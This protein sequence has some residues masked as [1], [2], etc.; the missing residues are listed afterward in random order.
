MTRPHGE[1]MLDPD[2]PVIYLT[3]TAETYSD[4]RPQA[5]KGAASLLG[6]EVLGG[7]PLCV[8]FL[9]HPQ[10]VEEETYSAHP[11]HRPR[12]P[13]LLLQVDVQVGVEFTGAP[14][15]KTFPHPDTDPGLEGK[16]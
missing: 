12:Q 10:V 15:G 16:A 3:V 5:L 11:Y 4:L 6:P 8:S 7:Q 1:P 13:K 2:Y 9:G 14:K